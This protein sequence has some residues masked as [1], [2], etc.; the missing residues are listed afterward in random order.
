MSHPVL[1]RAR[2]PP[3]HPGPPLNAPPQS[4]SEARMSENLAPVFAF[5]LSDSDV[6]LLDGLNVD[7]ALAFGGPQGLFDP[8]K[9]E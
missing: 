8:S 3:A 6:A 4:V 1:P 2:H 7:E 9:V 5:R